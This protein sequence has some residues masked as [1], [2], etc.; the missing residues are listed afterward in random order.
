MFGTKNDINFIIKCILTKHGDYFTI[1]FMLGTMFFFATLINVSEIGYV[2]S[3][4]PEDF[5]TEESY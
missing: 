1:C 2:K 5:L 4:K 3:L